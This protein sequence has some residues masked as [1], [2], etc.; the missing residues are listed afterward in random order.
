MSDII[1]LQHRLERRRDEADMLQREY[2]TVRLF[3]NKIADDGA[4][5]PVDLQ[6]RVQALHERTRDA[7]DRAVE[8]AQAVEVAKQRMRWVPR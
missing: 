8:A 3:V 7:L 1:Y 4:E 6:L 2:D 5:I